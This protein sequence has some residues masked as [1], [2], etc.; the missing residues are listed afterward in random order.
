MHWLPFPSRL[1][2][3]LELLEKAIDGGCAISIGSD[4][5]SRS[6][7]INLRFGDAALQR[8]VSCAGI[9]SDVT[10]DQKDG[11]RGT[12]LICVGEEKFKPRW[13]RGFYTF[14]SFSGSDSALLSSDRAILR[15]TIFSTFAAMPAARMLTAARWRITRR[16]F[17]FG[18]RGITSSE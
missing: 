3:P 8:D 14:V 4:S 5:H 17:P 6:H 15:S 10:S 1:D 18:L 12:D 11:L 9:L 7:L 13:T 16:A 2:L